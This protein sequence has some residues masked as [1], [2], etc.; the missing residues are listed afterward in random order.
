[1]IW[2]QIDIA[3]S[4]INDL[5]GILKMSA[6]NKSQLKQN[7]NVTGSLDNNQVIPDYRSCVERS[8][9]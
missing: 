5:S 2:N 3:D 8:L 7:S 4:T 6:S 9:E 1:V